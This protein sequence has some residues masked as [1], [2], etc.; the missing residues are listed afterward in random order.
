MRE[1]SGPTRVEQDSDALVAVIHDVLFDFHYEATDNSSLTL[2]VMPGVVISVRLKPLRSID[3]LRE[4]VRAGTATR[5][6][7]A[8][9]AQLLENQAG[10]LTEIVRRSTRQ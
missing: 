9:L 3:R 6:P 2:A 4:S 5:S 8:L 7:V 1:S 10:V